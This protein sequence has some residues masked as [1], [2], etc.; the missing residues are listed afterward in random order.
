MNP[1]DTL[2]SN[3]GDYWDAVGCHWQKRGH[4]RLWRQFSDRQQLALIDRWLPIAPQGTDG[5]PLHVLKT[6]LFDEVAGKGLVHHL[7]ARGSLVTG[8]DVSPMIVETALERYPALEAV[9][10]EIRELPFADATFDLIYSGSTLDHLASESE[11]QNAI[12]ELE[13]VLRPGGTLILTLDNLANPLIW[14]RNGPLYAVLRRCGIVPYQ[15]GTTLGPKGLENAVRRSGLKILNKTSVVH[16]PRM[17]AVLGSRLL[18]NFSSKVQESYCRFLES[19]ELLEGRP[20]QYL[21]GYYIAM[22]AVKPEK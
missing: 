10:A 4:Y 14:L 18:E 13:R 20:T 15:V 19:W 21:T 11:I 7:Q 22:H 1:P 2:T 16:C 12:L 5:P 17:F 6:D 9:V 8:I 3:F